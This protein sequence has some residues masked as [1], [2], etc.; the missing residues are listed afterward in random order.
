MPAIPHIKALSPQ[1]DFPYALLYF[2]AQRQVAIHKLLI[3]L[4]KSRSETF[5]AKLQLEVDQLQE[6]GDDI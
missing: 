1:M 4:D 3:F 6:C 5:L 2:E